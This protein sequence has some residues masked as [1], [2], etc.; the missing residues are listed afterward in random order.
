MANDI[1]DFFR[2]MG[3]DVFGKNGLTSDLASGWH[4]LAGKQGL[5]RDFWSGPESKDNWADKNLLGGRNFAKMWASM[6]GGGDAIDSLSGGNWGDKAVTG[7]KGLSNLF[8]KSG[9]LN[10]SGGTRTGIGGGGQA[11]SNI[12][13]AAP[14]LMGTD[15]NLYNANAEDLKNKGRNGDDNLLHVSGDELNKLKSTGKLTTN[16]ATGL[17]EAFNFGDIIGAAGN[18]FGRNQNNQDLQ[19]LANQ[20]SNASNPLAAPQRQGFQTQLNDLMSPN[21][22]SNFMQNDPSVQAQKQMIGDQMGAT[23][24]HSGNMPMTSIMGSAQL[25]N[26]F[27]GQ[28]NQRIQDLTTLGGY[29]Q[30]N[31][32]GGMPYTALMGPRQDANAQGM[33][34][35]GGILG[36][37]MGGGGLGGIFGG[38]GGGGGFSGAP[39]GGSF[40]TD[41][42]DF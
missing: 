27:G 33:G 25:A 19:G 5:I 26:A 7:I 29:N 12:F 34:G 41:P 22:A 21:G 20:A 10:S 32:Y 30:G 23:F 37:V 35:I 2:D 38:G 16:P 8:S 4:D 39:S 36:S 3:H 13:Q 14:G 42:F 31:P 11:P 6:G 9:S 28:Y 24:A 15:P 18:L 40:A 17:P 1:T